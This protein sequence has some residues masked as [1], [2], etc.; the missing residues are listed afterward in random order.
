VQP[1]R[2]EAKQLARQSVGAERERYLAIERAYKLALNSVYGKTIQT[3]GKHRPFLCP[4]WAGCITALTRAKLLDGARPVTTNLICFATDGLF[5]STAAPVEPIGDNLGDWE[6]AAEGIDLTIQSQTALMLFRSMAGVATLSENRPDIAC[7]VYR[8]ASR[9]C[10]KWLSRGNPDKSR[11]KT[12]PRE[13]RER[14][15]EFVRHEKLNASLSRRSTLSS[16]L[17]LFWI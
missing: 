8:R 6:L 10:R 17:N 9:I 3:V 2:V 5:S 12:K 7:E 13:N 15:D 4:M 1:K 16:H 11:L 14:C